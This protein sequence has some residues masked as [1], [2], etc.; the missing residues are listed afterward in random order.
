LSAWLKA[1]ESQIDT[2]TITG[3][4]SAADSNEGRFAVTDELGEIYDGRAAPE[5][6]SHAMI[7]GLYIARMRMTTFTST[8]TGEERRRPVLESLDAVDPT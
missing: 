5:L 2:V 3:S 1:V 7:D 6:L 8:V 4:L